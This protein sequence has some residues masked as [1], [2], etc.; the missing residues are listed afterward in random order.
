VGATP[1]IFYTASFRAGE[2]RA[3]ALA[4]GVNQVLP[5]PSE[6]QVILE[7]VRAILREPTPAVLGRTMGPGAGPALSVPAEGP[8]DYRTGLRNL[9]RGMAQI[10]EG[11][12]ESGELQ[13][14]LTR[15]RGLSL[16]LSTALEA[17]LEMASER[18]PARLM[19]VFAR[20]A[21]D[22]LSARYVG[23]GI[24]DWPGQSLAR[25]EARGIGRETVDALRREVWEG[26]FD[27]V[28]SSRSPLRIERVLT[29]HETGLPRAHPPIRSLLV[30]PIVAAGSSYGWLYAADRR[31]G[32]S[33]GDDDERLA[34]TLAAEFALVYEN[35]LL[36]D[37]LRLSAGTLRTTQERLNHIVSSSPAVIYTLRVASGQPRP[38]WLSGNVSALLGFSVGAALEPTWRSEH[39]HPDD[40]GA[41]VGEP[42]APGDR[43]A[44]DPRVP[45]AARRRD[46]PVDPGRAAAGA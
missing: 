27:R 32:P 31:P 42:C 33:F 40:E 38:E 11:V 4:C 14:S 43:G 17:V 29:G 45:P 44:H 15:V 22:V 12:T 7:A 30:V 37:D 6:P 24:L 39:L 25:F 23:V 20:A 13:E 21:Q 35:T 8:S 16:R 34:V 46:L 1:V 36:C 18:D 9:N 26:A 10:G 5:N 19:A 41:G 3:E 2:T 28:R